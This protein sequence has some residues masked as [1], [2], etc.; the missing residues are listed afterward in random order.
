MIPNVLPRDPE[1]AKRTRDFI[2]KVRVRINPLLLNGELAPGP[3][4]GEF[5]IITENN[6]IAYR[7]LSNKSAY[8]MWGG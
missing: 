3:G 5:T 1:A 7:V 8:G 4:A 6:I 2:D